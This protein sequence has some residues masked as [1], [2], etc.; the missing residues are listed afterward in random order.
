[1]RKK[2]RSDSPLRGLED[3]QQAEVI[4]WLK[5]LSQPEARA[6]IQAAHG[7][8]PG[9]TTL[10]KFWTW[11]HQ[12]QRF[13]RNMG[14]VES[15]MR[16][17]KEAAPGI[18]D[19]ELDDFGYRQLSLLALEEGD[20]QSF[21][22]LRGQRHEALLGRDKLELARKAEARAREA[23]EL[24]R[25]KF[26]RETCEMVL[27]HARDERV[28][29]IESSDAS[30]ADKL[31]ALDAILFPEDQPEDATTRTTTATTATAATGADEEAFAA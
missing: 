19:E 28:R 10:S 27:R 26:R 6:K 20:A 1:M 30:H 18:T 9:N 24:E 23:L 8:A 12:E 16:R 31:R 14:L 4:G 25:E 21:A 5:T 29:S 7:F 3:D 22:K 15:L 11:W 13:A 2:P 17:V